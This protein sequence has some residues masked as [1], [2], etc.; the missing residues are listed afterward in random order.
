MVDPFITSVTVERRGAHDHIRV[1]VHNQFVG[2]LVC[3][4]DDGE[5]AQQRGAR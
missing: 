1:F 2:E 3:G 4:A 5:R